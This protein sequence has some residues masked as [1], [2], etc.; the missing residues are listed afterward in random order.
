M[1]LGHVGDG[2]SDRSCSDL[3]AGSTAP[4]VATLARQ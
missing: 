1:G 3:G 2:H 4:A